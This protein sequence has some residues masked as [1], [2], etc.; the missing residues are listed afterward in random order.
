ME[1]ETKVME[2]KKER[3]MLGRRHMDRDSALRKVR[4]ATQAL[5]TAQNQI[6]PLQA[7]LHASNVDVA[8]LKKEQA[9]TAASAVELKQDTDIL[10]N[11][12]L[13]EEKKVSNIAAAVRCGCILGIPTWRWR[14]HEHVLYGLSMAFYM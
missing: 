14:S 5:D 10:I 1:M 4:K 6:P 2:H 11:S 7:S 13:K 8:T 3:D 12:F 9:K